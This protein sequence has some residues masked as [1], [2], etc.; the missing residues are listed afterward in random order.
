MTQSEIVQPTGDD[1]HQVTNLVLPV[2]HFVLDDPAP[3]DAGHRVLNPHFLARDA[4]VLRFLRSGDPTTAW[5]LDRLLDLHTRHSKALEP[6][7]LV[8]HAARR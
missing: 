5:F 7:V 8:E 2:A 6:P 1:H 3:L 4:L